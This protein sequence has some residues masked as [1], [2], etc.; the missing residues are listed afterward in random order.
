VSAFGNALLHD[1][2]NPRAWLEQG[3]SLLETGEH[4][5]AVASF[6]EA[7]ARE[8]R[9]RGAAQRPIKVAITHVAAPERAE[10]LLGLVKEGSGVDTVAPRNSHGDTGGTRAGCRRG[11]AHQQFRQVDDDRSRI[12]R[13]TC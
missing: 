1:P 8:V 2:E 7:I 6:D 3:L 4:A 11:T 10:S 13:K 5:G 9:E 12:Q